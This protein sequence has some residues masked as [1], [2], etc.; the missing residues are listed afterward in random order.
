MKLLSE[1]KTVNKDAYDAFLKGQFYWEKLDPESMLK[2]L[3]YFEL[4]IKK[5]PDWADPY[6]GL[7]SVWGSRRS[8]SFASAS[9]A[10]HKAYKYLDKALEIDPNSA[11]AHYVKALFAVWRDWE[12]G[13]KEFLKTLELNPNHAL[14]RLY[15][16]HLLMILRR[17]DEA[18]HQAS[19]GLE[20]DP[21]RPLILG[22]SGMVMI[23][24][25][26]YPAAIS[27]FE[28]ARTIAPDFRFAF[29]ILP[30]QYLN[31]DYEDWIKTWEKKVRWNDDAKRSVV[32]VF[33][34]KGHIIKIDKIFQS[35]TGRS[36]LYFFNHSH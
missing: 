25:G 27:A 24:K 21:M 30:A 35:L 23:D 33:Y 17:S 31:G 1:N 2:S 36:D 5:D 10:K 11:Q 20:L 32:N 16:A 13:E 8:G 19:L 7:A 12:L 15:Y 34:E 26:D 3:E 22:L 14:A 4:A 18:V 29:N 6:A 28:K 9:E